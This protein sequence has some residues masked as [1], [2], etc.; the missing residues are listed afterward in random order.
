[1]TRPRIHVNA[2]TCIAASLLL[3][4]PLGC[5]K[6]GVDAS[7]PMPQSFALEMYRRG[8]NQQHTYFVLKPNGD[9]SFAG[10]RAAVGRTDRR[11]GRLK[12]EQRQQLWDIVRSQGV[13]TAPDRA[14]VKPK[15]YLYNVTIEGDGWSRSFQSVDN[16]CPGL[17]SLHTALM[18][19]HAERAYDVLKF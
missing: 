18:K 11:V 6:P 9:L 5:A 19:L 14:F 16:D 12:D 4:A 17:E 10:G 15:A 8:P 2:S 13:T 7:S 3:L 1:M